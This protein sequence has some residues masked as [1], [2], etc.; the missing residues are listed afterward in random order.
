MNTLSD[1]ADAF[2]VWCK[3]RFEKG[4]TRSRPTMFTFPSAKIVS[5]GFVVGREPV[6]DCDMLRSFYEV[7]QKSMK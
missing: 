5:G 6:W 7:T 1:N 2:V 4:E 3:R